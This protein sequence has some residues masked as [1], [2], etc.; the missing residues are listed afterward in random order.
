ME[1]GGVGFAMVDGRVDF[2]FYWPWNA[3]FTKVGRNIG[4]VS[5]FI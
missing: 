2:D 4:L 5:L 1:L 3:V